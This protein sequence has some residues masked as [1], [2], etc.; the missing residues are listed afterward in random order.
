[1]GGIA[2]IDAATE[3]QVGKDLGVKVTI[4]WHSMKTIIGSSLSLGDLRSY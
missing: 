4:Q 3:A 2:T 1:V